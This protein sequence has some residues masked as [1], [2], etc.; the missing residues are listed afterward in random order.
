[1]P[2]LTIRLFPDPVLRKSALK[3][4]SFDAKFRRLVESLDETMRAQ[5]SGIGIAAPQAGISVQLALVDVSARVPGS[6]RRVLVNP[7]ILEA[8]DEKISREGCMSLPEYT[9]N[10]TRY[11]WIRLT[12][13][14]EFGKAHQGDFSG[15]EAICI[16]HEVDHL[17]GRLFLDRIS[18]LNRDL[19][20]RR[21]S[22]HKPP[23]HSH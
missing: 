7:K 16:Q 18:F 1:M 17:Q 23:R 10:L 14:D 6:K 8:R 21:L 3:V 15:I 5:S 12:W 11:D 19:I 4:T 13:Q 22:S 20:P 2:L 9:G